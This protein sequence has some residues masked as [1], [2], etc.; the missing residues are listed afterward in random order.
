MRNPFAK[1]NNGEPH[2]GSSFGSSD[3]VTI[4]TVNSPT[5][6]TVDLVAFL[7]DDGDDITDGIRSE[8]VGKAIYENEQYVLLIPYTEEKR[9]KN[10]FVQIDVVKKVSDNNES[11]LVSVDDEE[12][13]ARILSASKK[14]ARRR[15]WRHYCAFI[16]IGCLFFGG[17]AMLEWLRQSCFTPEAVILA[18]Y[19]HVEF[20]G[21]ETI[22]ED[23]R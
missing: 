2:E 12:V 14:A 4:T 3:G 10:V 18:R 9:R 15:K 21:K 19:D 13:T 5:S 11:F 1:K 16:L 23:V 8:V 7:S 6:C 20:L 22:N 17:G